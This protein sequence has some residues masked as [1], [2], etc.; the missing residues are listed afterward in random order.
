MSDELD[1]TYNVDT[2]QSPS[3]VF[4][5]VDTGHFHHFMTS[6][7]SYYT[8]KWTMEAKLVI[9]MIKLMIQLMITY[10]INAMIAMNTTDLW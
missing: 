1:V 10:T 9:A 6:I 2:V 5:E 8:P 7:V 3:N 4:D